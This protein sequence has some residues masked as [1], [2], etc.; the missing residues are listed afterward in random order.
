MADT[1]EL[2]RILI[3]LNGRRAFPPETLRDIVG[4]G[5]TAD[6]YN[7][8][9]GTRTQAEVVKEEGRSRSV[10]Q[11][12]GAL[13]SAGSPL[14]PRSGRDV[15]LLHLYPLLNERKPSGRAVRDA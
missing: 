11:G 13:G 9:D 14:S 3:Q 6:A 7:L 5:K 1:E 15:R 8:C 2:L 10:Q 12:V 4:S